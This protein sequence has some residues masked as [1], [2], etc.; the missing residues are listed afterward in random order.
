MEYLAKLFLY[1][2]I[3]KN[4]IKHLW[5]DDCVITGDGLLWK[6]LL[7]QTLLIKGSFTPVEN[8]RESEKDQRKKTTHTG[9]N[10]G[11]CSLWI[12]LKTEFLPLAT[13]V[14]FKVMFSQ[15]CIC[16]WDHYLWYIWPHST[17]HLPRHGTWVPTDAPTWDLGKYPPPYHW[18]LVVITGDLFKLVY[19]RTYIHYWYWQLVVATKTCKVGKRTV[20]IPLEFCLVL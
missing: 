11:F 13:K 10:I 15:A 20:H 3:V 9:G 7:D 14:C 4:L 8:E 12:G 2:P 5:L 19:L 18:H 16:L 6:R 17:Y 1:L